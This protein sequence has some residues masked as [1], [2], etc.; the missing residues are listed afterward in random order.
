MHKAPAHSYLFLSFLCFSHYK[1]V[2]K[3]QSKHGQELFI[4]KYMYITLQIIP[5]I[6]MPCFTLN[7][8]SS[9]LLHLPSKL[10]QK[11]TSQSLSQSLL[12]A[13]FLY[14]LL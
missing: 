9:S 3:L 13:K 10:L 2:P 4:S 6:P 7:I 11:K 1:A 12:L 8:P 5:T 14:F